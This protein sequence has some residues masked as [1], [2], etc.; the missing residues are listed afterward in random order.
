M[1]LTSPFNTFIISCNLWYLLFHFLRLLYFVVQLIINIIANYMWT[2]ISLNDHCS[3]GA[4]TDFGR[5]G[6]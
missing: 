5:V 6:H 2:C 3:G 1:Y 4:A